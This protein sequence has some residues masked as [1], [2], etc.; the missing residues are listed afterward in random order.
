MS[1]S[2]VWLERILR[3]SAALML[4]AILAHATIPIGAPL[5]KHSGSAFSAT[6]SETTIDL[7]RSTQVRKTLAPKLSGGDPDPVLPVTLLALFIVLASPLAS[8]AYSPI[9]GGAFNHIPR[10]LRPDIG[11]RA[12]PKIS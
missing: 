5:E 1:R 9:P 6:T 12:P 10:R 11:S 8:T 2:I 3:L 4:I 7:G